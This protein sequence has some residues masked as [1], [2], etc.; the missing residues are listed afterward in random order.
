MYIQEV[1]FHDS[2]G[3]P[4]I[5]YIRCSK[6][7]RRPNFEDLQESGDVSETNPQTGLTNIGPACKKIR[8]NVEV[9][10]GIASMSA[11]VPNNITGMPPE[12]DAALAGALALQSLQ[13]SMA[14]SSGK[15]SGGTSFNSGLSDANTS[16]DSNKMDQ[17][18]QVAE[19]QEEEFVCVLRPADASIPQGSS[20][21]FQTY[22]STASMVEHDR[23]RDDCVTVHVDGTCGG[24]PSCSLSN[25]SGSEDKFCSTTGSGLGSGSGQSSN[26]KIGTG[27]S[28][29]TGSDENDSA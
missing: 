7:F 4:T 1:C 6:V 12:S 14:I 23:Q 19:D 3:Y 25:D 27:T 11:G 15:T 26:D 28:S 29:E 20:V 9:V 22:L 16:E 17:Q 2:N 13:K 5:G 24:S 8:K 18:L 21:V 10:D